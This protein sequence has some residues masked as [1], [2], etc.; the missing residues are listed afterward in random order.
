MVAPRRTT[1]HICLSKY[2]DDLMPPIAKCSRKIDVEFRVVS[3]QQ[4]GKLSVDGFIC[5]SEEASPV[6]FE[7][8]P[9]DLDQI[10]RGAAWRQIEEERLVFN[11]PAI[12]RSLVDAV[13]D[14]RVIEH[15]HGG[16]AVPMLEQ[17]FDEFEDMEC[18]D[19][20]RLRRMDQRIVAEVERADD[21]APA[22]TINCMGQAA[23]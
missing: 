16:F 20:A 2:V 19:S 11:E 8:F 22:V 10:D 15:D 9:D 18:L 14:A 5:P 17:G 7:M 1:Q 12:Q 21:R 23:W 3:I 6:I 13:T 4:F